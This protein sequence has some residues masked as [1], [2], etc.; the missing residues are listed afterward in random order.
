MHLSNGKT[1]T[2]TAENLS[3]TNIYI[4]SARVNGKNWD[5]PFLPAKELKNG[6]SIHFVMGPQPN[7]EWGTHATLPE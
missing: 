6:G 4:Q 5:S 3:D 7:K 1:F 2:M